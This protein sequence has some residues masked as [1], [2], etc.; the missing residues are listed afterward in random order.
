MHISHFK[1][2]AF[3]ALTKTWLAVPAV[4]TSEIFVT[5]FTNPET[6]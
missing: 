1:N 6:E 2:I 3:V 4:A 5:E